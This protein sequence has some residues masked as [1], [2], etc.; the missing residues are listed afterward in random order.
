MT[1]LLTRKKSVF[2]KNDLRQK[3]ALEYLSCRLI[4]SQMG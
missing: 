4:V 1:F 2:M 3:Y